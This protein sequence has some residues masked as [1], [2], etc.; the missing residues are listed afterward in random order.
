MNTQSNA[1]PEASFQPQG[2][3]P[4]AISPG[5]ILYWS[6]RRELW[7]NRSI[8]IAP[9]AVAGVVLFGFLLAL[10]HLPQKMRGVSTLNPK[11]QSQ[12]IGQAFDAA[13]GLIMVTFLI[14]TVFYCL[15]ALY[16]ERRDRSIL[17]WKSLPVSDLTAVLSKTSIPFVIL[18]LFAVAIA[19]VTQ[20]IMLLL[21]SAVLRASGHG[22]AALWDQFPL[23]RMSLLLLYHIFTVHVLWAA[24]LYAWLLLVSAWARRAVFLWAVLPPFTI[25]VLEKMLLNTSHFATMLLYRFSGGGL[26]ALTVPGTMPMDPMT[27]ITPERFLSAPG[28]WIGLVVAAAFL[29]AAVRLRRY[30]GPI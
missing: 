20:F 5:R 7:E 11:Q 12:L 4:T 14:V 17:F 24:P 13:P 18:P 25:S 1:V 26:E 28:L 16:G 2:I 22:V 19:M 23:F 3:A 29:F 27:Q 8:Y 9:L 21:S 10:I 30:R 15:D 6:I